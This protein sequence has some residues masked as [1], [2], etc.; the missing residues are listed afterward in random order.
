M[1]ENFLNDLTQERLL[2]IIRGSDADAAIRAGVTL[3]ECG[4]R[5]LEVSLVT[6]DALRVIGEIQRLGGDRCMIGAGTVLTRDDVAR[7]A[8]AGARFM[9]TPA[10]TDSVAESVARGIPV[11]AGALTPTEV[12]TAVG[13]GATA[14]KL[15]PGS[16]GGP[17]YLKALRE[18]L[19]LV[20][21]VPVGGVT[22]V[23]AAEYLG[24]GAIAVGI[25]SPL[26]GDSVRGGDLDELRSR[27]AAF[28]AV[29]EESRPS[30]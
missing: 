10:V 30:L 16:V 26:L 13:L 4:I 24:Y 8:D 23:A 3:V 21:F 20:P 2:A 18:P 14:V 29:A 19:P 7:A 15:F 1:N 6:A 5:F 22:T 12:L 9:V 25:G 27:A 11:V 28:R 17:R